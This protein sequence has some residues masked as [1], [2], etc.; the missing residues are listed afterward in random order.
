MKILNLII[1]NG[2][3]IVQIKRCS[4]CKKELLLDHFCKNKSRKDGLTSQCKSCANEYNKIHYQKNKSVISE[5]HKEYY[6]NNK[7]KISE[8]QKEH[9]QN[10][11]EQKKEYYN[12]NKKHLLEQKKE[13]YQ[14]KKEHIKEY[15]QNNKE[16]I[17]EYYQKNKPVIR[18]RQNNYL[19]NKRQTYPIF[20]LRSNL[21]IGLSR[22]LKNIGSAKNCRSTFKL[23]GYSQDDLADRLLPYY[24]QLCGRCEKVELT[25]EN[26]NID[27]IL[28]VSLAK[29]EEEIIQLNHF[30]N[31]RLICA[32]CNLEKWNKLEFD[33]AILPDFA[34]FYINK[35]GEINESAV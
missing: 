6:K 11:K 28:P 8:Q 26:S 32:E 17:K 31:L 21:S 27:H 35:K 2:K 10:N 20:K 19:K 12:N 34:N 24:G 5:R 25:S 18:K 16:H 33:D 13:Y 14:N 22:A 15:R 3:M 23:L 1:L 4:K 30:S 29:T 9:Y 7:E